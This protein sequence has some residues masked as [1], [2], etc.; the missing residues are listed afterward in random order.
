MRLL[1]ILL[2]LIT[3]APLSDA[4]TL[5]ARL[6][7]AP[8]TLDWNGQATL[9]EA[10]IM[11]NICEGLFTY[12]YANKKLIPGLASSLKKSKDLTEY[13]FEIRS[14]AKWSDGRAVYA[15]DFVDAWVRLVSPQST[16]IYSYYLF[17]VANA[18]E[19]NSK[20]IKAADEIG[21][22][23]VGDRTLVVKLKRPTQNWEATTAFWPLFPIRK[24][25]MEKLGTNWWRAGV[26]VSSGPFIFDS[27][28]PGKKVI[29]KRNKYYNRS[30]S[31]VDQI[32]LNI[33]SDHEAAL[34]R[35]DDK[36]LPYISNLPTA[37][38]NERST[39]K[40]YQSIPLLRHYVM[41]FNAEKFPFNNQT[42][43]RAIV[44]AV[45]RSILIPKGAKHLRLADTFIPQPLPGSQKAITT[46]FNVAE[47]KELLKKS[48]IVMG[49]NS[50]IRI[51]TIISEPYHS[52]A[53]SIQAQLQKNLG[54]NVELA[55]LQSQ[56]YNAYMNLSDY[57]IS[58]MSWTAKVV[59]PQD[60]L[61]PYSGEALANRTHYSSPFYDQ[62][63][64]EGMQATTAK[65]AEDSF[66]HAQK[67]IS[68]EQGV[69][70]PLFFETS[71]ALIGPTVKRLYFDHMGLPIF[72][73]VQL[74]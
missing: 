45:D 13:T 53:K 62:W 49:P 19:Y 30:R 63:I 46:K 27:Y 42:F 68:N 48:G 23:A 2:A 70:N 29:L 14:D 69:L 41:A 74:N 26:L 33:L 58:L 24:D 38:A 21:V 17:G 51:L 57:N 72:R 60:F 3:L 71:G 7:A 15:Q 20:Q 6:A 40:D 55:A 50:K 1:S 56:E 28:E 16:S 9:E 64:F 8:V 44:T 18:R 54:L 12:D 59:S 32:Q 35:Y 67:F 10:P 36:L 37:V 4:K 5:E 43:R 73:D 39:R 31:N 22:K 52:V 34:K 25:L 65:E 11:I 47:A 61:L 66:Y